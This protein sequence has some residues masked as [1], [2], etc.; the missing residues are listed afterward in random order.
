MA[1]PIDAAA[2]PDAAIAEWELVRKFDPTYK[3]V[4]QY[5]KKA[6]TISKKLE[7]LKKQSN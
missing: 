2:E 4:D 6:R 3:Q 7:K 5:I 1:S